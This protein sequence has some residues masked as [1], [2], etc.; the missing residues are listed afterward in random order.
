MCRGWRAPPAACCSWLRSGEHSGRPACTPRG[1]MFPLSE[2]L[3]P[4]EPSGQSAAR[5]RARALPPQW[6][7]LDATGGCVACCRVS[8]CALRRRPCGCNCS[9]RRSKHRPQ[10]QCA[11]QEAELAYSTPLPRTE[12]HQRWA[13][14][15]H[16]TQL[17]ATK[18]TTPVRPKPLPS[19][20]AELG[21]LPWPRRTPGTAIS[22]RSQERPLPTNCDNLPFGP[23]TN[24]W[25]QLGRYRRCSLW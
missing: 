15:Q 6:A 17:F 1:S 7:C 4:S 25:G 16:R 5:L 8:G 24:S 2:P 12:Q 10:V 23:C 22:P 21:P 19:N 18:R 13:P 9:S 20:T 11:R 14:R 3:S